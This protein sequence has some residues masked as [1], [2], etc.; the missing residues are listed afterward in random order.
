MRAK[1]KAGGFTGFGTRAT[2]FLAGLEKNN[3]AT[4][5]EKHRGEWE[6]ELLEPAR[7]FV[8]ELG[9]AIRELAPKVQFEPKIGGSIFRMNRDTRFSKDKSPFRTYLDLWM[10][11]GPNR[12]WDGSGYFFRLRSDELILGAG[13]HQI[14]GPALMRYRKAVAG[15][16]GEKLAE[17]TD[18]LGEKG[19]RI[20]EVTLKNVPSGYDSNHERA[21]LLR[22]GAL[23]AELTTAVPRE[24]TK[25]GFVD[26]CV[27]RLREAA[28]L[29]TW[30]MD[31]IA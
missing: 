23:F 8:A 28:P 1:A 5:F 27:E 2:A 26:W 18:A 7:L 12:G 15:K 19:W 22:H 4:W 30:V 6:T 21:L 13:R 9:P 3:N 24:L 11:E 20:G 10:W 29:H 25:S 17:I 31:H 16:H 14:A